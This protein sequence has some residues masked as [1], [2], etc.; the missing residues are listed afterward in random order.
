M[1]LNNFKKINDSHGHGAGDKLLI[2]AAQRLQQ[3]VRE[4]DLVAR[5]GGDEFAAILEDAHSA[6]E[7]SR[8]AQ[9]LSQ[10]IEQPVSI[11]QH[12]LDFGVSIGIAV[13]PQD[14]RQK[15]ELE[16][17][18]DKV[19]YQAKRRGIPVALSSLESSSDLAPARA[20]VNRI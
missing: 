13:F 16:E 8:I 10:A 19:M 5:L 18:A 1:D 7:I 9:K 6:E 17:K 2:T 4:T 3:N 12:P 15:Q 14:G 11:R 20:P